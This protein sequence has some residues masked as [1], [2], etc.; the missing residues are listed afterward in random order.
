M[1]TKTNV[2]LGT[3][4]KPGKRPTRFLRA[5]ITPAVAAALLANF[6]TRNRNLTD[7]TVES[8][9]RDMK[10]GRWKYNGEAIKFSAEGV[11]TN[12]QH[13]LKASVVSGVSFVTDVLTGMEADSILTEDTGK[14]RSVADVIGIS[15]GIKETLGVPRLRSVRNVIQ[16]RRTRLTV[17]DF[18][19][20]KAEFGLGLEA[21]NTS[22]TMRTG[23]GKA[24]VAA[25]LVIAA[26]A[27]RG[28]ILKMIDNVL[29]GNAT[30]NAQR[31]LHRYVFVS[32]TI[33]PE[34]VTTQ[35]VL[36]ACMLEVTGK[37][38]N[39]KRL[40]STSS[41]LALFLSK[42]AT[43][44]NG[45]IAKAFLAD[46]GSDVINPPALPGEPKVQLARGGI[47]RGE[48]SVIPAPTRGVVRR[49]NRA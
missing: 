30:T 4:F 27:F 31:L 43:D 36:Y 20:L 1:Q 24:P 21:V 11:L 26:Q 10:S 42:I 19:D 34:D 15:T 35:K 25:A 39:E 37:D 41:A 9:A 12:G 49:D 47:L 2:T 23:L 3:D 18:Q 7:S 44:Q 6:N 28:P 38:G 46:T 14:S 48:V 22:L 32:S 16:K 13:R 29:A 40:Q 33:E 45:P 5:T 8:Y 17:A